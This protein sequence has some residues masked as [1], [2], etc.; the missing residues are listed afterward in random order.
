MLVKAIASQE[1]EA[2]LFWPPIIQHVAI[3]ETV[4]RYDR[5]MRTKHFKGGFM[6]FGHK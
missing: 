1:K 4:L 5:I 3:N 2:E 6:I